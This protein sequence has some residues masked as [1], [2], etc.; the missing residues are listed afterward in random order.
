MLTLKEK[1]LLLAEQQFFVGIWYVSRKLPPERVYVEDDRRRIFLMKS[2]IASY[3]VV[4]ELNG[5]TEIKSE[6]KANS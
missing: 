2:G 6:N 1:P 3:G 4:V 5:A